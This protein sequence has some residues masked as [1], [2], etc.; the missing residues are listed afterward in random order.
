MP[1]NLRLLDH[2]RR[3]QKKLMSIQCRYL[4]PPHQNF[5][6]LVTH[7]NVRL[8]ISRI[9]PTK[10]RSSP[11]S[12]GDQFHSW[13]LSWKL[14]LNWFVYSLWILETSVPAWWVPSRDTSDLIGPYNK[15]ISN[16]LKKLFDTVNLSS[17]Q[18]IWPP[19]T[20][21]CKCSP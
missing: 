19:C 17:R 11:T 7:I 13:L 16:T 10:I 3:N 1:R 15:C 8:R 2:R 6:L 5:V 21:F 20:Q 14:Y 18:F 12:L 9:P 4:R